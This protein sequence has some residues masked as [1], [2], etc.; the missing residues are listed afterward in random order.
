MLDLRDVN[1]IEFQKKY[2]FRLNIKLW[3]LLIEIVLVKVVFFFIQSLLEY[4]LLFLKVKLVL[5]ISRE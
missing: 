5:L 1:E 2:K 4:Y 3:K